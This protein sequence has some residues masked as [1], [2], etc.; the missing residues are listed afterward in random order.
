MDT[1]GNYLTETGGFP[2]SFNQQKKWVSMDEESLDPLPV[3]SMV[4]VTCMIEEVN[5][6]YNKYVPATKV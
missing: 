1:D 3:P 5:F 4:E 2:T 6:L